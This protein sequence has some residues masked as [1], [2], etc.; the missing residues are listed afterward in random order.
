MFHSVTWQQYLA[1]LAMA[2]A[3]YYLSVWFIFKLKVPRSK[4]T[5]E[6]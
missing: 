1:F 2:T 3:V 5:D 4:V 6:T